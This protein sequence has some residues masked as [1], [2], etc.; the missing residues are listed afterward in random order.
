MDETCEKL[1]CH[2]LTA[3]E[4]LR[5]KGIRGSV[6]EEWERSLKIL[7][8]SGKKH[9]E[10]NNSWLQNVQIEKGLKNRRDLLNIERVERISELASAEWI[11]SQKKAL[12]T[13]RSGQEW[14]N[15]GLEKDGSLYLLPEETLFLIET[16]CLELIWNGVPCSVQQAYEILIDDSVCTLEEYRVY[17]QLTRYGYRIQRF[18]YEEP[19]K[20]CR[21]DE[22]TK[23]K[24]I[25]DPES[26]LR[27]SDNQLQNQQNT[28][29]LKETLVK[30]VTET[31]NKLFVNANTKQQENITEEPVDQVVQDV[32]VHLLSSI[33]ES[34]NNSVTF[35]LMGND[36]IQSDINNEENNRNSKPE[37]IS[38]ETLLGNIKIL[39]DTT[40]NSK[41][42]IKVSKWPGARIQRNVKQLPKRSDKVL[43]PEISVIDSGFTNKSSKVEKRKF[44]QIDELSHV[45]KSK[46]EVIE[47]SDDEI[48]ELPHC[49][50]RIE[51]LNL[52]PNIAFQT[53]ITEKILRRYIPH[54]IR[55]QKSIYQYNRMKILRMQENDK[56]ARQNCRDIRTNARQNT[57]HLRTV[58][59]AINNRN[60]LFHNQ[61]SRSPLCGP[62]RPFYSM[63]QVHGTNIGLPYAY[64]FPFNYSPDLYV[65]NR[66]TQNVFHNLFVAFGNNGN[67]VQQS[68][69]LTIQMN[70]FAMPIAHME[71][72]RMRHFF[73]ENQFRHGFYQNFSWQQRFCQR[74]MLENASVHNNTHPV[75][76]R[77]DDANRSN[78]VDHEIVN[79]PSFTIRLGA[80]SWTELKRR[81]S[82]EKTITID[83]ED[84]TNKNESDEECNEVQVVRL[85]NPLIGPR[86]V[87]SLAEIFSKLTIIK[88][89]PERIVRRKKNRH[90]ISYNVYSC[91]HH[92][93]KANPGQPLY[94]LVVI[95][96]EDSFLQPVELN[97]LQQDAKGSQIILAYVSMS[98]SYIQPGIITIPN[99]ICT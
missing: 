33:E 90:K 11:P 52:L 17:S 91:T 49:M 6:L 78:Q 13:K 70:N 12:V 76:R 58:P 93:R 69:S 83:D 36:M 7:P 1:F 20:C 5:S 65:Q 77:Y 15:F 85:I 23:R 72:Y 56:R 68:R 92:Y 41:K 51:M 96:K 81:W 99:I 37:I 80:S 16:N 46:H 39:R 44:T 98:I 8:N 97:R 24:I 30:N 21:S 88:P 74:R 94:S 71:G 63:D 54:N 47:L 42:V 26:G 29:K 87:S 50:T 3:E 10:P 32:M 59:V 40:C 55:P 89:A 66:I 48:Q 2:V 28:E 27:M 79:R 82:E 67:A 38:D 31:S 22:F 18:F 60:T 73:A 84:Y 95:R 45:K 35:E 64:R 53:D 4:L 43:S 19:E 75:A 62:P 25:V 86:N 34:V 14:N 57:S 9:F 61:H